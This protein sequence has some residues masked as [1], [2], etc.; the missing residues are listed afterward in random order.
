MSEW[1]KPPQCVN[2]V[3]G[4]LQQAKTDREGNLAFQVVC[5]CPDNKIVGIG[6]TLP[7]ANRHCPFFDGDDEK[8]NSK[9]FREVRHEV[10]EQ[11]RKEKGND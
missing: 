1:K 6:R 8:L 7:A 10:A 2:C 5:L 11:I 9:A 3:W 4:D